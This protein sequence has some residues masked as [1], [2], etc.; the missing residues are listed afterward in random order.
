MLGASEW[1]I[2]IDKESGKKDLDRPG[3]QALKNAILRPGDT[4]VVKSLDLLFNIATVLE[5]EPYLLLK[6]RIEK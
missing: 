4:L 1:D 5:I 2:I 6:F 3:Y